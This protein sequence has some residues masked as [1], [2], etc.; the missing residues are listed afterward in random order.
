MRGK[1]A[2]DPIYMDIDINNDPNSDLEF[3]A[4]LSMTYRAATGDYRF[5]LIIKQQG[6]GIDDSAYFVLSGD[7]FL[8]SDEVY[9]EGSERRAG[10]RVYVPISDLQFIGEFDKDHY[11]NEIDKHY[12]IYNYINR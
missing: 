2:S 7:N 1:K 6:S 8:A 5:G 9:S 4:K 12:F 3:L 11:N 10:F